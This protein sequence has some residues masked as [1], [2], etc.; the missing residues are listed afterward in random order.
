MLSTNFPFVYINASFPVNFCNECLY[1]I[2]RKV[3]NFLRNHHIIPNTEIAIMIHDKY[4][5]RLSNFN[6]HDPFA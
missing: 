1:M 3:F 6:F 2:D 4:E 5:E